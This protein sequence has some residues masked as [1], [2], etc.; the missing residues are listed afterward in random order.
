MKQI[1]VWQAVDGVNFNTE[2]EC[3]VH[4]AD[5]P[6]WLLIGLT[7]EDVEAAINKSVGTIADAL[8]AVGARIARQRRARGEFKRQRGSAAPEAPSEAAPANDAGTE[9]V[10]GGASVGEA[11]ER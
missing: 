7:L 2:E 3:R 1:N 8:E 9:L 11:G 10:A 6:E 4:E 5:H